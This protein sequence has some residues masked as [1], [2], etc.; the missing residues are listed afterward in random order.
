MKCEEIHS[1]VLELDVVRARRPVMA[2]EYLNQQCWP[3]LSGCRGF[4]CGE[5]GENWNTKSYVWMQRPHSFSEPPMG[6]L[7]AKG[8]EA[9]NGEVKNKMK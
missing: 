9:E 4:R 7:Y 5:K 3:R 6:F 1:S 8:P 2:P